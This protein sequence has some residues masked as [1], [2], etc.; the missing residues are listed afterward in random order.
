MRNII[1]GSVLVAAVVVTILM[2]PKPQRVARPAIALVPRGRTTNAQGSMIFLVAV[3]NNTAFAQKCAVG[4]QKIFTFPT[5]TDVTNYMVGPLLTVPP[6]SGLLAPVT[7]PVEPGP[8]VLGGYYVRAV[9]KAEEQGRI[10]AAKANVLKGTNVF[11]NFAPI[12]PVI[13]QE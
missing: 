3:T 2:A 5:G 6:R 4:P 1:I 7:P 13:V 11:P 8:W 12:S 10:L 9:S